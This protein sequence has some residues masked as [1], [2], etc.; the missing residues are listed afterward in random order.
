MNS[1]APEPVLSPAGRVFRPVVLVVMDGWG[2]A[3]DGPGTVSFARL[4]LIDRWSVTRTELQ[5][6]AAQ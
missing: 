5:T 1:A 2:I 4:C 6:S 3:P